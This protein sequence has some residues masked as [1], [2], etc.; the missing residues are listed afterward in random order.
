MFVSSLGKKNICFSFALF[1]FFSGSLHAEEEK[2][3][4]YWIDQYLSVSFPLRSIHVN[5]FYGLRRDPINGHS[6]LHKGIDLQARYEEALSMFDGYVKTVG[7]GGGN[8]KYIVMNYGNYSI[9]YCHLSEI[10]VKSGELLFSGD[11][12]GLTGSTGRST[13]PHLHIT[14]RLNG[15][16][17]DPFDLLVY[18]K[19]VKKRAILALGLDEKK[20]LTPEE[21]INLYSDMAKEHQRIYGIPAS[22]TLAQMAVESYWG[23]SDL[24][25]KGCNYFGIKA[26]RQWISLGRPFFVMDDDRPNEKFCS[27]SSPEASMEYHSRL[28]MGK[29]YQRCHR[30]GPTDYHGWLVALKASGYATANDYVRKCEKVIRQHHLDRFDKE[31]QNG[32]F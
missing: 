32:F 23:N 19:G 9:T 11:P 25:R 3:R 15:R 8:G 22:V 13:G 21:F 31:A 16:L 18:I 1:V 27:F 14:V 12:V 2:A 4:D 6:R 30:Y 29:T 28:L 17:V 10:W 26:N 20:I 5:S 24:A 7:H